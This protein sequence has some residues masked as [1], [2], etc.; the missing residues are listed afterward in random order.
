MHG[1]PCS[2]EHPPPNHFQ[3]LMRA[4]CN[5]HPN[6]MMRKPDPHAENTRQNLIRAP[7]NAFGCA[8]I[9]GKW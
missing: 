2:L 7:C 1:S 5:A 3:D 8:E 9:G 6:D 4:P